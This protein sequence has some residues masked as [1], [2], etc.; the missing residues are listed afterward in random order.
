MILQYSYCYVSVDISG[1]LPAVGDAIVGQSF[2]I[3]VRKLY[4]TT[5]FNRRSVLSMRVFLFL[6]FYFTGKK[7][8][9]SREIQTV[10]PF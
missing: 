8:K 10:P 4:A 6:V 5:C 3:E 9:N 1:L 2:T 7:N